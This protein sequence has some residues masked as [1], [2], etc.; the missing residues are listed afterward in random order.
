MLQEFDSAMSL[1]RVRWR[2]LRFSA[3]IVFQ[4]SQPYCALMKA[5]IMRQSL[6]SLQ[7]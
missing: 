3:L 4:L 7:K 2:R 5:D 1:D 6:P